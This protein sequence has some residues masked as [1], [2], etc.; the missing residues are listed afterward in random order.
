MLQGSMPKS[1]SDSAASSGAAVP[2]ACEDCASMRCLKCLELVTLENSHASGRTPLKRICGGCSSTDRALQ[3]CCQTKAKG[4]KETDEVK[5]H[6]SRAE[7]VK[8]EVSKI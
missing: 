7:K 5:E 3:R 6:R 2:A 1:K 8:A 4:D